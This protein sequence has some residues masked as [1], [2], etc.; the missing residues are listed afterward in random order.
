MTEE[1]E[2]MY[3]KLSPG[4]ENDED[5]AFIED[6]WLK[7]VK[8]VGQNCLVHRLSLGMMGEKIGIVIGE[9]LGEVVEIDAGDGHIVWDSYLRIRV[10]I[11]VSKSLKR[12]KRLSL[13][14]GGKALVWFRYEK[15][16]DFFYTCDRLDHKE[17][18]CLVGIQ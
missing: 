8:V 2:E 13:R 1:I 11:D 18:K 5:E 7:E 3:K 17:A 12:N 9:S 16:P 14:N 10:Y 6:D 4:D 15:L